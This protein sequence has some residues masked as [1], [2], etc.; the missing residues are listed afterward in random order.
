MLPQIKV[1]REHQLLYTDIAPTFTGVPFSAT[2]EFHS[3]IK[4]LPY[5]SDSN[6]ISNFEGFNH[7]VLGFPSFIN[8]P[9]SEITLFGLVNG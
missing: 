4:G 9:H 7:K 6:E 2:F 5:S 3:K 1:D 8:F